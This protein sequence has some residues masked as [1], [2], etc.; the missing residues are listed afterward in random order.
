[1]RT[2]IRRPPVQIRKPGVETASAGGQSQP[3]GA[4]D[5]ARAVR[6]RPVQERRGRR[7]RRPGCAS[8]IEVR[9]HSSFRAC[10]FLMATDG[11]LMPEPGEVAPLTP[12]AL[13]ENGKKL[14]VLTEE[15]IDLV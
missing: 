4:G 13:L 2:H 12:E 15:E 3:G 1:A 9:V 8:S 14:K 7:G 10:S 6:G 11:Q 5:P